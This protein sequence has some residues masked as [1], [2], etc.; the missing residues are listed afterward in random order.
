LKGNFII[1]T[2]GIGLGADYV[3][4]K[5]VNA[6]KALPGRIA[7]LATGKDKIDRDRIRQTVTSDAGVPD[8]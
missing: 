6:K 8:N 3:R 7:T 1:Q 4:C 2:V 5:A